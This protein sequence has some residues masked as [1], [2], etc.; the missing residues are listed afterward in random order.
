MKSLVRWI[1]GIFILSIGVLGVSY[2]QKRFDA[3][4]IRKA[5]EALEKKGE[6]VEGCSAEVVSRSRGHVLV[7]CREGDWLIDTV[8]G[9]IGEENH[10]N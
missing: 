4:D 9:V 8:Q 6:K 7:R 10:G 3:S 2:L 1:V 5:Y